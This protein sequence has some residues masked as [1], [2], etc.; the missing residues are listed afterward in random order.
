MARGKV[1]AVDGRENFLRI[2]ALVAARAD[3]RARAD[4]LAEILGDGFATLLV[5]LA[6]LRVGRT[7]CPRGDENAAKYDA[8]TTNDCLH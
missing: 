7:R 6:E 3:L 4:R 5:D 2:A 8:D 1:V